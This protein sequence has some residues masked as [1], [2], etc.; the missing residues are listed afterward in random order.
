MT[1]FITETSALMAA[2]GLTVSTSTGGDATA[3]IDFIDGANA[4][5]TSLTVGDLVYLTVGGNKLYNQVMVLH[6]Y[7]YI[8]F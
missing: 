8:G 3:E 6:R 5:A 2:N 7:C 4:G 1:R